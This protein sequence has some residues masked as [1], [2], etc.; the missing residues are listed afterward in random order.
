[1]SSSTFLGSNISLPCYLV[2]NRV[3]PGGLLGGGLGTSPNATDVT[4]PLT[5]CTVG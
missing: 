5:D 1:M 4:A 2:S 3:V